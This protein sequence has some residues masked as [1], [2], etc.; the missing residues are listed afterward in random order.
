M[1][2]VT[3]KAKTLLQT[4]SEIAGL[5]VLIKGLTFLLRKYNEWRFNREMAKET[6]EEFRE[7]FTY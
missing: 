7:V 5:F 6:G 3:Y 1:T 4:L 2:V